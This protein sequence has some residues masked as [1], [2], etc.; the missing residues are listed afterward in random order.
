MATVVFLFTAQF[1]Q[2]S[3]YCTIA[4]KINATPKGVYL[5]ISKLHS[6]LAVANLLAH[7]NISQICYCGQISLQS[8]AV[9]CSF[10]DNLTVLGVTFILLAMVHSSHCCRKFNWRRISCLNYSNRMSIK[11]ICSGYLAV[12]FGR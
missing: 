12:L 10:S 4:S 7:N 5:P 2:F 6:N 11:G 1:L 9:N 3:F 8:A